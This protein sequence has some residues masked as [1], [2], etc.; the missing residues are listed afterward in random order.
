MGIPSYFSHII[1]N[2][3]NI[4]RNLDFFQKNGSFSFHHLMMDCNSIIYDAF[5]SRPPDISNEEIEDHIIKSVITKIDAYIFMIRPTKTISIAFDGVAPFAKMEQQRTRRNKSAFT[6]SIDNQSIWN[7]S[8]IT[9]GTRFMENLSRQIEHAFQHTEHKYGVENVIVSCSNVPGEGEHKLFQLVRDFKV[10]NDTVAL[11]GLDSD[12]LML[13]LFHLEYCE[14][15]YVFRE[16]PEFLKSAIQIETEDDGDN[17]HFLDMKHFASCLVSEMG[18]IDNDIRRIYDYVFMCFLLGND[19][20]PHF[21]SLNIRTHGIQRLLDIYKLYV[22]NRNGCFLV[23]DS[24]QIQWNNVNKII[25]QLAKHEHEYITMEY[26]VRDKTEKTIRREHETYADEKQVLNAPIMYRTAEMYI[27]PSQSKWESRYYKTLFPNQPTSFTIKNVCINYLEGLEWVLKYYT[28]EC[29]HWRWK[30]NHHYPPLFTDLIKYVPHF[31]MDFITNM[32]NVRP[33]TSD[34][35]L[36]YVLP[37]QSMHLAPNHVHQFIT[38]HYAELYTDSCSFQW[39]FCR[40]F[41]ESHVLLPD[42]PSTLLEQWDSQFTL[43]NKK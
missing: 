16:A 4:I 2:F 43:F 27:C 41:W 25:T 39:A 37:I 23:S 38:K 19:F 32:H 29:P 6:A 24:Y 11:Y 1:R 36:A 9:P 33:F 14:N 28:G 42:I 3:S 31:S 35:Q 18:C 5:H 40:Y 7:T 15:I 20:L 30:Y 21:P 8:A 34:T 10:S 13:S 26:S 22:G 12:L 17:P